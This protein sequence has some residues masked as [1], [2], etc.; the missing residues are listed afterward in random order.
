MG[1]SPRPTTDDQSLS[2]QTFWDISTFLLCELNTFSRHGGKIQISWESDRLAGVIISP[3]MH[4]WLWQTDF[5][6]RW[7]VRRAMTDH[8]NRNILQIIFEMFNWIAKTQTPPSKQAFSININKKIKMLMTHKSGQQ[9]ST[10]IFMPSSVQNRFLKTPAKSSSDLA[11]PSSLAKNVMV[12]RAKRR[13]PDPCE[14]NITLW[15]DQIK[16]SFQIFG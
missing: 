11:A 8:P 10:L 4:H 5:L 3:T 7:A 9:T 13:E 1:T 15:T 2:G 16:I 14:I 6:S 12:T